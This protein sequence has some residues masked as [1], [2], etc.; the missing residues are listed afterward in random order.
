MYSESVG[1]S[2][3]CAPRN[4]YAATKLHDEH[5][6]GSYAREHGAALT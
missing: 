4:V 2:A 1:E 5:L 6:L 3:A